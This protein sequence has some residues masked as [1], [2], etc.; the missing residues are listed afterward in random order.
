MKIKVAD[1]LRV[2]LSRAVED[3]AQ[4][5]HEM[6]TLEH[7][8]LALLHDPDSAALLEALGVK[9]D[10]LEADLVSF[11]NDEMEQLPEGE[12]VEPAQSIAFG[13]VLQRAMFFV[14]S[15]KKDEL[16]GPAVLTE[17]P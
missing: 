17:I 5:R 7:L 16:D 11:L 6:L 12:E 8:L 13:T 15:S 1:N 9:L 4:R 2:A 14:Q 3:T 10:K